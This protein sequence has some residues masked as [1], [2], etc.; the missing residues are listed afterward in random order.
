M[1]ARRQL[2]T[3]EQELLALGTL[4]EQYKDDFALPSPE[5]ELLVSCY[6]ETARLFAAKEITAGRTYAR[7]CHDYYNTQQEG[8]I[9][10]DTETGRNIFTHVAAQYLKIAEVKM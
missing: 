5:A 4:V 9:F 2:S 8:G 10:N 1:T 7:K 3:L 6:E